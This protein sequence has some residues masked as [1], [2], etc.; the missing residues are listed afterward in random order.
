MKKSLLFFSL[1][2]MVGWLSA[3]IT[4]TNATFPAT[5]DTLRTATDFAPSG[6]EITAAGGPFNWDFSGLSVGIQS[7]TVFLD[8]SEGSVFNEIPS[9][10]HVVIN[11]LT[12]GETYFRV[13]ADKVDLLGANGNDPTGFGV[14][15]LFK[16]SPPLNQRRAPMAF[17]SNNVTDASVKLT[18]A[19]SDLPQALQDAIPIQL[20]DSIRLNVQLNQNDFVDAYGTLAIPGGTY[21]VLRQK[22]T[23]L[24]ETLVEVLVFGF[25]IDATDQI[26]PPLNE[27][28]KDTT[29]TYDYY[30]GTEKE[31]IASVTVDADDNPISVTFKDN[32]MLTADEEVVGEIPTVD[33]MP[34]PV[35]E[36]ANFKF[37]HFPNGEYSMDI[38]DLNGK[39]V[40]NKIC[41]INNDQNISFNLSKLPAANYFFL[42]KNNKGKIISSGKLIKQ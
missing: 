21:E 25:W 34:N 31:V 35:H 37:Q 19:W 1:L 3:Q 22:H 8:A 13:T 39:Q 17:P 7:E 27:F 15:A 18:L 10:T 40:F 38:F 14:G 28:L 6:I 20:A 41:F 16:F 42:L 36:W 4:V 29:I 12:G 2:L 9:A 33:L 26:P 32:G 11:D 23:Q 24:T 30:S 5:G